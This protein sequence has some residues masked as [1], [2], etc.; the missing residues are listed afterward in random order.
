MGAFV[1]LNG[2]ALRAA[3]GTKV[4]KA[5]EYSDFAAAGEI[6][7][8]AAARAAEITAR[9]EEDDRVSGLDGGADDYIVKPFSPRELLARIR[10]AL[11]R[12]GPGED[13]VLSFGELTLDAASLAPLAGPAGLPDL[14]GAAT[15]AMD[16]AVTADLSHFDLRISG[17]GNGISTGRPALDPLLAGEISLALDA[18]RAE[19]G[20]IDVRSLSAS[21]ATLAL[22]GAGTL[23]GLPATL[24][25]PPAGL[26]EG[27]PAPAFDGRLSAGRR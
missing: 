6:L 22:D 16:G 12:A 5:G 1:F 23:T 4:I 25:P 8:R 7:E 24:L 27:E 3:P 26:L 11:R 2:A 21:T 19:G 15:L 17:T 9:A 20:V 13:E 18:A 14:R 10:A